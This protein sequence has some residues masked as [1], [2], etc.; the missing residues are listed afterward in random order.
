MEDYIPYRPDH[1]EK[2][3]KPWHVSWRRKGTFR[4]LIFCMVFHDLSEFALEL[5]LATYAALCSGLVQPQE[6]ILWNFKQDMQILTSK[7]LKLAVPC[8]DSVSTTK[9]SDFYLAFIRCGFPWKYLKITLYMSQVVSNIW[10][11][12]DFDIT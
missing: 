1:I 3:T 2:S 6:T 5:F 12:F 8:L 4:K 11:L 7:V 10:R 9:N